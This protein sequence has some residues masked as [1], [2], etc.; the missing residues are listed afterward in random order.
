MALDDPYPV[1]RRALAAAAIIA[2][3]LLVAYWLTLPPDRV[4]LNESCDPVDVPAALSSWIYD[5][6]FW[7]SQETALDAEIEALQD[8]RNIAKDGNGRPI[9]MTP[10]EARMRRL[11]DK[12]R[13]ALVA[14]EDEAWS[15]EILFFGRCESAVRARLVR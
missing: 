12:E 15:R 7:Q 10:I 6:R 11:S 13:A 9:D 1:R 3:S 8:L 5:G 14:G 2:A 4:V